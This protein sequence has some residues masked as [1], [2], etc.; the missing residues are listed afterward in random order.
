VKLVILPPAL[1]E[2]QDAADFYADRA[3]RELALAFVAEFERAAMMVL[4]NPMRGAIFRGVSRRYLLRRFPYGIIYQ[5][6]DEELRIVA[7]AHH[8]RRPGYW[9]KR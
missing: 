4:E 9:A 5:A 2:L 6:T 3:N 1:A 8:S 7:V